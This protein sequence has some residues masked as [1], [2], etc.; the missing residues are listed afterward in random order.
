[1][2][3]LFTIALFMGAKVLAWCDD[4]LIKC[5]YW[6]DDVPEMYS[7]TPGMS[8]IDASRLKP[9]LHF[10]NAYVEKDGVCSSAASACFI[11]SMPLRDGVQFK[12]T[13]Y[14][15]D[16]EWSKIES[17][18]GDKNASLLQSLDVSSLPLGIHSLRAYVELSTGEV[19][20]YGEK[21]FYRVPTNE[22]ITTLEL[23]YL[24]DDRYIGKMP[25]NNPGV[26][27]FDIDATGLSVG[28][29]NINVFMSSPL[30]I[31][32]SSES[33][34]FV[35][36]P[37]GGEGVKRYVYWL[38]EKDDAATSVELPEV[39][40][41]YSLVSL[42]DIPVEPFNSAR[43]SFAVE[44]GAPVVYPR[45]NFNVS[46]FDA[47][48]RIS[49]SSALFT[50]TRERFVVTDV[51]LLEP[52]MGINTGK[53]DDN[54]IKW[55][56]FDGQIGDSI[57]INMR[58]AAMYELYAPDGSEIVRRQGADATYVFTST[59]TGNGTYYLAVHD[60]PS[61]QKNT[62]INFT[63]IDRYAILSNFPE[64]TANSGS[65]HLKLF[66][67]GFNELTGITL[68]GENGSI[69][70]KEYS[71]IDNYNL[72]A[73]FDLDAES[74]STG[75][76]NLECS[77]GGE[78]VERL[79]AIVLEEAQPADICVKIL[80]PF[81][82]ATPYEVT[83][84]V[85]NNSNVNCLGVPFNFAM[86]SCPNGMALSFMNFVPVTING[87]DEIRVTV[88]ETDNLLGT[89]QKGCFFPMII[90]HIGAHET[91]TLKFGL[92]T[93]PHEIVRM[94]AWA[95]KPWS[96]EFKE[97]LSDDYDLEQ[98]M[99]PEQSNIMTAVHACYLYAL[100]LEEME[101]NTV[102]AVSK[103]RQKR[104]KNMA[105]LAQTSSQLYQ[106][107]GQTFSGIAAASDLRGANAVLQACGYTDGYENPL[108]D[109]MDCKKQCMPSPLQILGTATGLEEVANVADEYMRGC[110]TSPNPSPTPHEF[111]VPQAGDP[112][113]MHGYVAPG[114]GNHIGIDVKTV[115]YT[116]EFE[117]DPKIATAPARVI[118]VENTLDI[119]KFDPQSF[120]PRYLQI[121]DRKLELPAK[122]HFVVTLDMRTAIN[123]LA[124][125][126]FDFDVNTGKA[127]WILKSLDPMTME[128]ISDAY[129]GILPVND[130][131]GRGI[132]FLAFSV[133]LKPGLNDG[134]EISHQASII[135][136][137]NDPI[138]TPM[139]T[140]MTDY[141]RPSSSIGAVTTDDNTSFTISVESRDDGA[142]IWYYDLYMRINGESIWKPVMCKIEDATFTYV[143]PE[144]VIGADFAVIATDK[145]GNRQSDVFLNSLTGD[146]DG[147]G[148]ID[149]A[150]AVAIRLYYTGEV[151]SINSAC[152]DVNVDG[153]IDSQDAI[154]VR[155]IYLDQ[156]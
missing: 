58:S 35:R 101:S 93:E 148:K 152:A 99:Q 47:A 134:T 73:I 42:V 107:V 123:A 154:Y 142:G 106:A 28:L 40:D 69:S 49:M 95:G 94:Y 119:D 62:D 100:G 57:A 26:Y 27:S 140:N 156:K 66:G 3:K 5:S 15:D 21:M 68:T 114:G 48:G 137:D 82:P 65:L 138:D 133:D 75:S 89:G 79:G 112:N 150:D 14:I 141:V 118:R 97:I 50:D 87:E 9:G 8:E 120:I 90:P 30:G 56:S 84:E 61:W 143:H 60:I 98:I 44:D 67:N 117:N 43:Y 7:F 108:S 10:L 80:T 146:A 37:D 55:Y 128:S 63:H 38:N 136:D 29:H 11:K 16:K 113:D 122:Q 124:Q 96:E 149:A 31:S 155:N 23:H 129:N 121:G 153:V 135:F 2:R 22:E 144:A 53:I 71:A 92:R 125:L 46:F 126:D 109:Y 91:K 105:N 85:T 33:A 36:I 139:W 102:T 32:T 25:L 6:F 132:G 4:G 104:L 77:Y 103:R 64:S 51:E 111:D 59:L 74:Y 24:I 13:F 116:I 115:D 110:P 34:W 76:Y 88:Y 147:N 131:S 18:S 17:T 127:V 52:G 45:N 70:A 151:S 130:D 145:A 12:T 39:V 81:R 1:M 54:H 83:M 19:V 41:P 86:Q 20:G 78:Q 72:V